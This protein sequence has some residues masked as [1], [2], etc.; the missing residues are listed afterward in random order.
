MAGGM[1]D[2]EGEVAVNPATGDVYEGE[3]NEEGKRHGSGTAK[4]ANGDVYKGEYNEVR[5]HTAA[6]TT[7]TATT[8]HPQDKTSSPLS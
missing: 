4:Y 2:E 7:S 1:G 6:A 3:R 8:K 5:A